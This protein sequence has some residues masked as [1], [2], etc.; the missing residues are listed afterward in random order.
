VPAVFAPWDDT[1]EGQAAR[2]GMQALFDRLATGIVLDANLKL[3]G[4]RVEVVARASDCIWFD[5]ATLCQAARAKADYLQLAERFATVF[6]SDVPRL[7][8][9]DLADAARRF[10]WLVDILY[11]AGVKLVLGAAT[12]LEGLYGDGEGGESGRTLSRLREMQSEQYG[13]KA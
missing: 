12:D 7:D 1:A 10:T 6:L 13:T 9:P 3:G 8:A 2:A 5:F 11:D 4:R